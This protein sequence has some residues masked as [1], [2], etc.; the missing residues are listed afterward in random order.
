M[1]VHEHT[2]IHTHRDCVSVARTNRLFADRRMTNCFGIRFLRELY[3]RV[4]PLSP[5]ALFSLPHSPILSLSLSL[6]ISL[7]LLSFRRINAEV[8]PLLKRFQPPYISICI[9]LKRFICHRGVAVVPPYGRFALFD[10][11]SS[12]ITRSSRIFVRRER[13]SSL[14]NGKYKYPVLINFHNLP[15]T[16]NRTRYL[17]E[18]TLIKLY[19]R[20]GGISIS[21]REVSTLNIS[22]IKL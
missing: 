18:R 15:T 10:L 21:L 6:S 2:H 1:Y 13:E 20:C 12:R 17:C 7:A 4:F 9:R 19:E 11:A 3:S 22:V 5:H 16:F 8:I 14:E